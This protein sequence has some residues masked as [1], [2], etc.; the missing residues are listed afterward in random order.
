M[1]SNFIFL[2]KWLNLASS[3]IKKWEKVIYQTELITI[4]AVENFK[5]KK[6][7]DKY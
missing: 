2:Y 7:N 4:R 6:N 5:Y 3:I 1:I